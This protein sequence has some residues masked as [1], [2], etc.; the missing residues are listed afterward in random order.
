MGLPQPAKQRV[1]IEQSTQWVTVDHSIGISTQEAVD[2]L[3]SLKQQTK[4]DN[5]GGAMEPCI[6]TRN[7]EQHTPS[8]DTPQAGICRQKKNLIN[9]YK[10]FFRKEAVDELDFLKQQTKEDNTRGAME[11]RILTRKTEQHTPSSDTPQPLDGNDTKSSQLFGQ[12]QAVSLPSVQPNMQICKECTDLS[13][14]NGESLVQHSI[15]GPDGLSRQR[16][17]YISGI[18]VQYPMN[19]ELSDISSLVPANLSQDNLDGRSST[20][21]HSSTDIHDSQL[22]ESLEEISTAYSSTSE[23]EFSS[24]CV[25]QHI[26]KQISSRFSHPTSGHGVSDNSP[27]RT[28]Y[29]PEELTSSFLVAAAA[30]T[31]QNLE[32][33]GIIAGTLQVNMNA[34][35][36]VATALIIPKQKSTSYTCEATNEEEILEV[37]EQMCSPSYLGWIHTHPTQDCFMSSVDLHNHYSYQKDLPEAFA[38]VMAPSKG[39]QN[40]F[41]LTVPD[42]MGDI[43]GC[44]ARGFHPHDMETYEECSHLQWRS[45]LSLHVVDLRE[46]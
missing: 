40:A 31:A 13:Y 10:E 43:G 25:E 39:E 36:F 8:S 34:E 21:E 22:S 5:T 12:L 1:D 19:T 9:M 4:E 38:I 3:D 33:C 14:P 16:T 29:V 11:P 17:G 2:A 46:W 26:P 24:L 30:N 15:L 7:T 45:A 18:K 35:Y 27:Y 42:G 32:T 37:F 41:H 20:S 44:D 23:E 6:L 28:V